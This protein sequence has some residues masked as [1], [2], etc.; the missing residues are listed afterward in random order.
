MSRAAVVAGIDVGS[1]KVCAVIGE[2]QREGRL[3]LIGVG[4][5][6]SKGIRRGV[7]VNIEQAVESIAA[8]VEKAERASGYKIVGALVTVSAWWAIDSTSRLTS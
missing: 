7:V 4:V 2:A 6:P 3:H 1:S 5:A 8:A